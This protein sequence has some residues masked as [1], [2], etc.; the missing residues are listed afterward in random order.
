MAA[1]STGGS[2]AFSHPAPPSDD[3]VGVGTGTEAGGRS[4]VGRGLGDA[5]TGGSD[6]WP[7]RTN[8]SNWRRFT[9]R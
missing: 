8:P 9:K 7:E 6:D 5:A 3:N 2:T 4:G 1:I